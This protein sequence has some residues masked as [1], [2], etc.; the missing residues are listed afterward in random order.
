MRQDICSLRPQ[1]S[2]VERPKALLIFRACST[3]T[4]QI[5]WT[6]G[7]STMGNWGPREP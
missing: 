3:S 5:A 1:S 2:L 7:Q 6:V 4:W